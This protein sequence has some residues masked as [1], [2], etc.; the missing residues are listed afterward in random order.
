MEEG[1]AGVQAGTDIGIELIDN[2]KQRN[3]HSQTGTAS[4]FCNSCNS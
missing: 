2:R 1:V 3:H 4:P